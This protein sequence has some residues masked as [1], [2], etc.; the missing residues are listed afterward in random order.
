M[1]K[2]ILFGA[3]KIAR[4]LH[5][6]M[7]ADDRYLV[8][9]FTV[10][11]DFL[12]QDSIDGLPVIPF[13]EITTRFPPGEH[14]ILV[15]IGYREMN[16]I[17]AAK[18][19]QVKEKGYQLASYMAPDVTLFDNVSVG[20]NSIVLDQVSLQPFTTI[21]ENV[22]IW[23]SVTIAHHSTIG[24]NCWIASGTVVGGG[25]TVQANC[26]L[27]INTVVGHDV[28]VAANNFL[29]GSCFISQNT[30]ANGVYIT[31]ATPKFRLD[32]DKFLQF[33]DI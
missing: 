8:Q 20:E 3:G 26:F 23:S 12:T 17:R 15:A 21:G 13:S 32:T 24:N 25:S 7:Q 27:G 31:K 11:A 16:R 33:V 6:Y 28:T 14:K 30:E 18:C 19:L 22:C 4:V 5:S 29:G 2:L 9:A 1:D 10:D